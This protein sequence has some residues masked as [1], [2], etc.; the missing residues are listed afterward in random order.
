V[1]A[2]PVIWLWR[3]PE[4]DPPRVVVVYVSAGNVLAGRETVRQIGAGKGN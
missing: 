1:W 3:Q 2:L 4:P